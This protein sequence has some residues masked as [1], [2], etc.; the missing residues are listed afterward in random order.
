MP[1]DRRAIFFAGAAM[2]AAVLVP[3]IT[4]P[5]RYVPTAVAV[6]YG[7]L[8]LASFLDWRTHNRS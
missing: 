7:V 2:I 4:E 3:V 5:L 1:M 8:A 6:A